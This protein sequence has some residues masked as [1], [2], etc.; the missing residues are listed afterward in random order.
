M[1]TE[2]KRYKRSDVRAVVPVAQPT[3]SRPLD[4]Y[5]S[6]LA[7]FLAVAVQFALIAVVIDYW[8]LESQLLTRLLWLA[9]GGFIIHHLLPQRFR[10]PFFAMLPLMAVLSDVGVGH[11]GINLGVA[12]LTGKIRTND[13]LYHLLPDLTLIGIGLGL[14]GLCHL[15]IR[16]VARR[17]AG[18]LLARRRHHFYLAATRSKDGAANKTDQVDP[19]WRSKGSSQGCSAEEALTLSSSFF[20]SALV[21]RHSKKLVLALEIP[22]W[23]NHAPNLRDQREMN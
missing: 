23:P 11:I 5:L 15:P 19:T 20:G 7:Q 16:F 6:R 18:V 22:C 14:M 9:F 2:T 10:L 1:L 17:R 8:Q 3:T 4:H 13:L 12:W 21:C